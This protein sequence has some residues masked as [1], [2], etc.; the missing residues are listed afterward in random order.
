MG[1]TVGSSVRSHALPILHF[2]QSDCTMGAL[3]TFGAWGNRDPEIK[4]HSLSP[5]PSIPRLIALKE[6]EG[7]ESCTG[8]SGIFFLKQRYDFFFV[9]LCDITY[10]ARAATARR[11]AP[12]NHMC[13]QRNSL[14]PMGDGGT[15]KLEI[16][17]MGRGKR[18]KSSRCPLRLDRNP[19]L[20][21]LEKGVGQRVLHWVTSFL[22]HCKKLQQKRALLSQ[23]QACSKD[24]DKTLPKMA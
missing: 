2:P 1:L 18:G 19:L 8:F 20:A 4:K 6:L 16:K 5:L 7:G 15:Q 22:G 21:S 24:G 3:S 12:K 9:K 17:L 10:P 14:S 23:Q 13:P 11:T